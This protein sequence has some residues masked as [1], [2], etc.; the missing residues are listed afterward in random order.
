M[1][2]ERAKTGLVMP[3]LDIGITSRQQVEKLS[4]DELEKGLIKYFEEADRN[5]QAYNAT[6]LAYSLG[7]SLDEFRDMTGIIQSPYSRELTKRA[8]SLCESDAVQRLIEGKPPI[9]LIFYLKNAFNWK[10]K[11]EEE[12][13]FNIR[14]ERVRYNKKKTG[15]KR[16]SEQ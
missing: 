1:I 7:F 6:K 10:D 12:R 8:L 3:M 4:P 9:G 5:K 13:T 2:K 16:I 11:R 15:R 14:V